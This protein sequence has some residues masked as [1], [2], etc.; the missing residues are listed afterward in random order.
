MKRSRIRSRSPQRA[1]DERRKAEGYAVVRDRANGRCEIGA[2]D[3]CTGRHEQTHHALPRS[4]SSVRNEDRH[5]PDV[6]FAACLP[7]H[8]HVEVNR[9]E[10]M[11]RGWLISRYA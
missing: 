10:A 9:A 7:C 3:G 8:E 6:L 1:A 5:D 4:A 11:E 2:S